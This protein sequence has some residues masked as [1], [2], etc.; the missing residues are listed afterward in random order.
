MTRPVC[1]I[2]I[3]ETLGWAFPFVVSLMEA[4]GLSLTN[5]GNAKITTWNDSGDQIELAAEKV[6]LEVIS[7]SVRNIQFWKTVSED[8]FVAWENVQSGCTFSFYLDGLDPTFAV[9]LASKFA[10]LVLT[11]FRSKYDGGDVLTISFE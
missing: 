10:E 2:R 11:T 9:L 1:R 3:P 5:P 8:V 6:H 4:L 7:G